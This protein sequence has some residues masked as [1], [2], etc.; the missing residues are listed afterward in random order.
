MTAP[1]DHPHDFRLVQRHPGGNA[2]GR[3]RDGH[4]LVP[5]PG[6]LYKGILKENNFSAEVLLSKFNKTKQSARKLL[7]ENPLPDGIFL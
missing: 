2:Q 6:M 4:V 3:P 1:V 7:F 5:A